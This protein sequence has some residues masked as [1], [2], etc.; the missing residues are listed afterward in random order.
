M[1]YSKDD[2]VEAL[3]EAAELAGR[4][5]TAGQYRDMDIGPSD[6]T[7]TKRFGSWNAAKEAAGLNVH[8][9]GV[10]PGN[11]RTP[12]AY[13]VDHRGYP[14]WEFIEDSEY[15]CVRVHRL[16]AVAEYGFDAV[17]D[18]DVHHKNGIPWDNRP[19]NIEPMDH[20]EHTKLHEPWKQS[21]ATS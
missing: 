13:Y 3:Q 4:D 15:R 17:A 1:R 8:R 19:V 7:I 5:L 11:K 18:M 20:G 14:H 9:Q 6:R 21:S 10:T 12:P 2:C 16:L